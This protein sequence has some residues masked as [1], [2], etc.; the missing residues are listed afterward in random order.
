MSELSLV[1]FL[2]FS[3]LVWECTVSYSV[4]TSNQRPSVI[5]SETISYPLGD[6]AG[7]IGYSTLSLLIFLTVTSYSPIVTGDEVTI[8]AFGT[9]STCFH[10]EREL[11]IC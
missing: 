1:W 2:S 10:G 6:Y 8:E 4:Y 3:L 11:C 7:L 5:V 9:A